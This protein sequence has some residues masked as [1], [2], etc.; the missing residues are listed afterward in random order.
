MGRLAYRLIKGSTS[1]ILAVADVELLNRRIE[2]GNGV[3]LHINE[4]FYG[5]RIGDEN[6][7]KMLI[8]AAD[9]IVLVG[10]RAVGLGREL[11]LVA[12]GSEILIGGVPYVQV[13][14]SF[15]A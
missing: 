8:D 6:D 13:L 14:R 1:T 15:I 3:I 12:P 2:G 11:G 7:V 9:M 4:E 10:P 5:E